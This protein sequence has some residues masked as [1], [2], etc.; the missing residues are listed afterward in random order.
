MLSK[1]KSCEAYL[2]QFKLAYCI[3]CNKQALITDFSGRPINGIPGSK[4]CWITLAGEDGRIQ[5]RVG[6]VALCKDCD[7]DKANVEEIKQALFAAIHSGIKGNEPEWTNLPI[8]KLELH[9]Q[10]P[11]V[12]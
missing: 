2:K 9:Y 12:T 11:E 3:D 5:T 1:F 7:V 8:H 6:T 10:F 4:L